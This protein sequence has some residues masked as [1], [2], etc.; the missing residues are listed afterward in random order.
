MLER[1][2]GVP[3]NQFLK[4]AEEVMAR[5]ILLPENPKPE[6]IGGYIAVLEKVDNR[7]LLLAEIGSC[8][9]D[10]LE[11]LNIVQKEVRMYDRS[12]T[13]PYDS[14]GIK[15]GREIVG[16]FSG[17]VEHGN[18]AFMLVIWMI[19]RWITLEDAREIVSIS[20]NELFNPLLNACTDLFDR[21]VYVR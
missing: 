16:A 5:F 13:A 6:R 8:P 21:E 10:M 15:K 14:S 2:A 7:I 1:I 18:E 11:S 12:I 9:S 19:F 4:V 17:L 3:R 20:K